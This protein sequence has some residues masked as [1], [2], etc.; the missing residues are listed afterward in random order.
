MWRFQ[1]DLIDY[2]LKIRNVSNSAKKKKE[3]IKAKIVTQSKRKRKGWKERIQ[4]LQGEI[5]QLET[6]LD[7]LQRI[8]IRARHVGDALAYLFFKGEEKWLAPLGNNSSNELP[9]NEISLKAV[10][11][12]AEGFSIAGAGYPLIHDAT[13]C[14][15]VGDITFCDITNLDDNPLT[16]K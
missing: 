11:R 13:N 10:L 2:Q 8:L 6:R 16:V 12:V 1:T 14:L 7:L 15:R 9:D 4:K 5:E 3:G